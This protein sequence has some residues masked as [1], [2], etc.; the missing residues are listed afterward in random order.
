MPAGES[1]RYP[2][3]ATRELVSKRPEMA[4]AI[5]YHRQG[6]AGELWHAA[7]IGLMWPLPSIP[8]GSVKGGSDGR[9]VVRQPGVS[10]HP[11][12]AS[13]PA[14][15]ALALGQGADRPLDVPWRTTS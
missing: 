10:D 2:V 7:R 8:A 14:E 1:C 5:A 15:V 3:V 9:R 13:G 6:R 4:A 12:D 11:G